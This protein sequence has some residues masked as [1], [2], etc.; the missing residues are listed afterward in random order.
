M[1]ASLYTVHECMPVCH[2]CVS[3]IYLSIYLSFYL[4]ISV[5][6]FNYLSFF[7]HICS[8][9]TS[10]DR[11]GLLTISDYRSCVLLIRDVTKREEQVFDYVYIY[12]FIYLFKNTIIYIYICMYLCVCV[13]VC[14]LFVVKPS[15]FLHGATIVFFLNGFS[16]FFTIMEWWSDIGHIQTQSAPIHNV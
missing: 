9:S 10:V 3:Y 13:K 15:F 5:C 8:W 14:Q 7:Q 2:V 11:L 4:S 1:F 6:V 12:I 16:M